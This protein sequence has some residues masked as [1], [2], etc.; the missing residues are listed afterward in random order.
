MQHDPLK[1]SIHPM[2][3]T[4]VKHPFD[5]P[6]WIFEPKW[7]G[8]RAIA[9]GQGGQIH[10]YSRNGQDLRDR[11]PKIVQALKTIHHSFVLDGEIVILDDR[12][13]SHFQALQNYQ[14]TG[15]GSLCY[16]VFDLLS[17]D[18]KDLCKSPLLKR[19]QALSGLLLKK[20]GPILLT[21]WSQGD[22][23]EAFSKALQD[24]LEGIMAKETHSLYLEGRRVKTWLKIKAH[25]QQE[26]VICGY[27]PPQHSR[28]EFGALLLG[29]REL[30]QWKYAGCVGTGFTV[31]TLHELMQQMRPLMTEQ[32]PFSECPKGLS[33]PVWVKPHL[34]CEVAFTEWTA[35]EKLRHPSF[36]GLRSD[37]AARDVHREH[38]ADEHA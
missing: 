13:R 6:D 21:P 15:E 33:S 36:L 28:E 24:E 37:K 38:A 19:K 25:Q 12:G 32:C 3:A 23:K 7:D 27:T 18:G 14:N 20:H 30:H 22:G 35:D 29:V 26:M 2:L 4:L 16:C 17:L 11:Y 1:R 8:F 31:Q 34:V 5:D 9:E 10:L